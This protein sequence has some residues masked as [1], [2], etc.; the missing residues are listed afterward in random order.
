MNPMSS[1][2]IGAIQFFERYGANVYGTLAALIAV[3]MIAIIAMV[4]S[5]CKKGSHENTVTRF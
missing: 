2:I 4:C 5:G 1:G 3:F